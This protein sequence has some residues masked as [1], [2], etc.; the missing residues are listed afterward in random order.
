MYTTNLCTTSQAR[1]HGGAFWVRAPQMTS[2][3]PQTK[4]VPPKRGLCPK[5]INRLRATGMQIEAQ[6][7]FASGIFVIFVDWHWIS[8]YFWDEDL[9]FGDHLYSAGKNVWIS[10]F[11]RK[12]LRISVKT[13]F[14]EITCFRPEKTFEF[15]IS[16]GKSLWIFGLHLVHLIQTG[17]N[18]SCPR[19]PLKFT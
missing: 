14:L 5:E 9:F 13:F 11:C 16:V 12:P 1:R 15:L 10:D 2:C 17:I 18:F 3:A 19:A 6:L 8:W 4:I 7:V